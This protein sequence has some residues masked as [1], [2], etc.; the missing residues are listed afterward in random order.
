M[1]SIHKLKAIQ[2]SLNYTRIKRK[3]DKKSFYNN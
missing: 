1:H 3:A 2:K